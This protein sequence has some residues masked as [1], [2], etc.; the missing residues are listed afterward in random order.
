[1]KCVRFIICILLLP[2]TMWYAIGVAVRNLLFDWGLKRSVSPDV[3]TIGIGNLRVGG[4]GKTPHTE[5]LIRLLAGRRVA[6]LSRGYGRATQGFVLAD[7]S[8]TASQIGDEPLMMARKFPQLTVAV[9]EDRVEGVRRLMELSQKPDVVLLDDVYQHRHIRPALNILLTEYGDPYCNDHILPFGNL[10][11]G[12]KG[13]RRADIVVVTKCPEHLGVDEQQ[14]M[15]R[16]LKLD[17]RQQLFFSHISYSEPVAVYDA[18]MADAVEEVVLVTGIAHPEPLVKHLSGKY[19]VHH[20]RFADH[21]P[22]GADDCQR[23][24]ETYNPLK[25]S[26]AVVF[27][28]EKDAARMRDAE[29]RRHLQSLPLFYI[30][31]EVKLENGSLFDS[32]IQASIG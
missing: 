21:H 11:E 20:L 28:T 1:M 12:R 9:C 16:K 8:S 13:R 24:I 5:Y 23:I 10:R 29:A 18:V 7:D 22:F 30:P 32:V 19:R 6:L 2:L 15:R 25:N 3:P 4:T 17:A 31:I 27:T 14:E 26:N